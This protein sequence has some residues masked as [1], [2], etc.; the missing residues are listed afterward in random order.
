VVVHFSSLDWEETG[1]QGKR[2]NDVEERQEGK[3][4]LETR[5]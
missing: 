3:T 4:Q 5:A 2:V 1:P